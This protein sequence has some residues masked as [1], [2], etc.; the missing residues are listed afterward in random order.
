MVVLGAD[1]GGFAL[2]EKAK[3]WL[4][5]GGVPYADVGALTMDPVDDYPVFATAA[6]KK[7]LAN[8]D[9]K[10]VLFCRSGGGMAIAA[11]RLKGVRAVDCTTVESALLARK[12]NNANILSIAADWLN[13]DQAK[14]II[15]TF[16]ETPFPGEERHMRRIAMLDV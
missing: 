14:T 13:E 5:G 7:V 10:A 6:A 12:K 11:N 4:G 2:K 9:G 15:K 3:L 16:L 1:H 8:P